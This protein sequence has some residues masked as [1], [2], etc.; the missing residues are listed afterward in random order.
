M[1]GLRVAA[2]IGLLVKAVVVAVVCGGQV[3]RA[4]AE[5]GGKDKEGAAKPASAAVPIDVLARSRGFHA[6]LEAVDRRTGE[7]DQREHALVAREAALKA[8]EKTLGDEIARL[9]TQGGIRP[10][11]AKPGPAATA[12]AAP[13]PGVTVTKIYESMKPEEAAPILDK[14]DDGTVK[15]IF[16]HM[17]EKQIGA[18]LAVMSRERA[19][20]LTKALAGEPGQAVPR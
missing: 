20:A 8:L 13:A 4:A 7:L 10:G 5:H 11:G 3:A 9:E 2:L 19:V 14:L 15:E 16:G 18:L 1:R 6:L 12:A 17:K